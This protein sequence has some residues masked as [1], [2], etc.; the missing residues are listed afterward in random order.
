MIRA[1]QEIPYV[2]FIWRLRD[3]VLTLLFSQSHNTSTSMPSLLFVCYFIV[4]MNNKS[5]PCD[6]TDTICCNRREYVP[7]ALS[8]CS[9]PAHG[10]SK[11]VADVNAPAPMHVHKASKVH[12][13]LIKYTALGREQ[14]AR[15]GCL[16]WP[17]LHFCT[18]VFGKGDV[19]RNKRKFVNVLDWLEEGLRMKMKGRRGGAAGSAW[20][21]T[22]TSGSEE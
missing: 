16:P 22:A 3:V 12:Q 7:A 4:P 11:L 17:H 10:P 1:T 8:H 20:A 6:C 15:V 19:R 18:G 13:R 9:C 5:L 14:R 2:V 21:G